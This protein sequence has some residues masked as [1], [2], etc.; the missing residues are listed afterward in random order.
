MSLELKGL[1]QISQDG[2]YYWFTGK[3]GEYD[4]V[5][6]ITGW[7]DPNF[8]LAQSALLLFIY[9]MENPKVLATA[10]GGMVKHNPSWL[11]SDEP[12]FQADYLHDGYTQFNYVR[13]MVSI[14]DA[15]SID[16][17]PAVFTEGDYW[18]NSV[19]GEIKQLV[20]AVPVVQDLTDPDALD[21]IAASGSVVYLLCERLYAKQLAVEKNRKYQ[22]M[23]EAR[24]KKNTEQINRLRIDQIDILLGVTDADYQMRY[25]FKLN[26]HDTIDSLLDDF[27]LNSNG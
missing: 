7:G 17:I 18:Y 25:G 20:S 24:R 12:V 2:K 19:S 1:P 27:K 13:L 4:A 6:N 3:T 8:E 16:T 11:N 15:Q 21:A 26:A 22:Q 9:R 14:D 23:V 10:I 5:N